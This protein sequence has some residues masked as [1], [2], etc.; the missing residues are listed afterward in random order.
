MTK[1][2]LW[3]VGGSRG[4]GARPAELARSRRVTDGGADAARSLSA[5]RVRGSGRARWRR[6][7]GHGRTSEHTCALA[8]GEPRAQ[9]CRSWRGV[10]LGT[11]P[12][13]GPEG[14]CRPTGLSAG[15]AGPRAALRA[16]AAEEGNQ[17][18][19]WGQGR[20][21]GEPMD[22]AGGGLFWAIPPPNCWFRLP[23]SSPKSVWSRKK[24]T[25][26]ARRSEKH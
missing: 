21:P 6:Q 1:R 16:V 5:C 9:S 17:T 13:S 24:S 12:G 20:A 3:G 14:P 4:A 25:G 11:D 8:S 2:R 23:A 19:P 18:S 7:G 26:Q 10:G 15:A 22:L